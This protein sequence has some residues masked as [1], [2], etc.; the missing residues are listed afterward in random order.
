MKPVFDV[1]VKN[2]DSLLVR[3]T[4]PV[5]KEPEGERRFDHRVAH[6]IGYGQFPDH[7]E[8]AM[9][10]TLAAISYDNPVYKIIYS[11]VFVPTRGLR[12]WRRA[13]IV[14]ILGDV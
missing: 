14:H 11:G 6:L 2:S 13:A 10:K 7:V 4:Y 8:Y 3:F 1:T 12:A 9:Y 5:D